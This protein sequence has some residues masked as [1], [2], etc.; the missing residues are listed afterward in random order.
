MA[1]F[2]LGAFHHVGVAVRNI[3]AAAAAYARAFGAVIESPI[4]HDEN[5]RVRIQFMKMN[6]LRIELLEPA[7]E[8]SPV[9]AVLKRGLAVY[10]VCH[11]VADIDATLVQLKASGALIVSPAKP[12]VAFGGRRVAFVMCQ[13]MMVELLERGAS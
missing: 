2:A 1:D 12:A 11:E 9:E 4:Y 13:G 10:H 5:Q 6:D 7:G 8:G 3:E